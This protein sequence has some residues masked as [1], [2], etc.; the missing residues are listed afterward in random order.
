MA[1]ITSIR[2][3]TTNIKISVCIQKGLAELQARPYEKM[4]TIAQE[5]APE[6]SVDDDDKN[7]A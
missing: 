1:E 4:L 2:F 6:S 5:T 3:N 7:C